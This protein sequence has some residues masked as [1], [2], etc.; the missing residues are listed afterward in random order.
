MKD[1]SSGLTLAVPTLQKLAVAEH[2]W[3]VENWKRTGRAAYEITVGGQDFVVSFEEVPLQ[4][5]V[6]TY[7][8]VI[9]RTDEFF[10]NIKEIR[11]H[12]MI[13]AAAVVMLTLPLVW[14]LGRVVA[15]QVRSLHQENERIQRFEIDDRPWPGS[16]IR[17]ID[18][19]GRS[20]NT[21]KAALA[22][23][24]RFVP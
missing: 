9:A 13:A 10:Q 14:W 19:L 22:A 5:P 8:A 23:F 4:F 15:R 18:E 12:T 3:I 11:L 6:A 16:H 20:A 24:G 1:S 21:M 2:L 17:E 7:L